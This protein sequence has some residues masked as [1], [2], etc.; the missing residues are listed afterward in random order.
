MKKLVIPC[1][2]LQYEKAVTGFGQRNLFG[3]GDV[4]RWHHFTVIMAQM[5]FLSLT[6][7]L[8][9]RSMRKPSEKSKIFALLLRYR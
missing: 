1:L 3:D 9:M 7:L 6:F 4:E 2:Y 8:Q 5:N